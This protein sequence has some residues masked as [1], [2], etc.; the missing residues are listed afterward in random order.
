MDGEL[1]LVMPIAVAALLLIIAWEGLRSLLM[2][3]EP[4]AVVVV[5]VGG[6]SGESDGCVGALGV[7]ILLALVAIVFLL[8]AS[9]GLPA[10]IVVLK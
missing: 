3:G 5:S 9:E 8:L 1:T 6:G 10:L 4:P 7:L 2:R